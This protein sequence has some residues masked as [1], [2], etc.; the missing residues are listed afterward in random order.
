MD[1]NG[2]RVAINSQNECKRKPNEVGF[3]REAHAR[4]IFCFP[5]VNE[6][7]ERLDEDNE[8]G[9]LARDSLQYDFGFG[10]A[11]MGA[12]FYLGG[13]MDLLQNK[14][15]FVVETKTCDSDINAIAPWLGLRNDS[16]KLRQELLQGLGRVEAHVGHVVAGAVDEEE[17]DGLHA[18][19]RRPRAR[20]ARTPRRS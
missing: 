16:F 1:E 20:G 19:R 5:S 18:R 13:M 17:D 10:H 6:F 3:T 14:S 2:Q 8:C 4:L 9:R 7:A 15:V 11:A 12:C